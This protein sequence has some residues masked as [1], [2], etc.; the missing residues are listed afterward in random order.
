MEKEKLTHKG[1]L[2]MIQ[3]SPRSYVFQ[4]LELI[5][6]PLICFIGKELKDKKNWWY[7]V[8]LSQAQR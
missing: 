6:L 7:G 3:L 5:R 2:G 8:Y 4:G 1:V